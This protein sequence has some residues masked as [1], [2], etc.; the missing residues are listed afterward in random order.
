MESVEV[1]VE[2]RVHFD[3]ATVKGVDG[4]DLMLILYVRNPFVTEAEE[5]LVSVQYTE[6]HVVATLTILAPECASYILYMR[7]KS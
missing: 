5:Y 6:V 2:T 3:A 4:A 1:A 7:K